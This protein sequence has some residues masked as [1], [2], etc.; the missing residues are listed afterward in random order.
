MISRSKLLSPEVKQSYRMFLKYLT[1]LLKPGAGSLQLRR[2]MESA[3]G[4]INKEWLMKMAEK[5][6]A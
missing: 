2:S 6:E 1:D 4:F 5:L 3:S